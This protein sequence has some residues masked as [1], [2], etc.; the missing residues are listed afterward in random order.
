MSNYAQ[1]ERGSTPAVI[2][3]PRQYNAAADF[4]DRHVAEGRGERLALI[5]DAGSYSYAELQRRIDRAGNLL[6]EAGADAESRVMLC[7]LD[8]IDFPTLFFGAIKSGAVAVPVNTLLTTS[9]YDFMLRD[10]RARVLVVSRPLFDK[11]APILEGQPHLRTVIVAGGEVDGY[12]SLETLMARAPETLETADTTRDD[13][14]FWLYT[15]GSTGTPKGAMHLHSDMVSTAVLYGEGVLGIRPDDRIFS[16]AKM[17]FAYGLGNAISFPFYVGATTVAMAARPTPDAVMAVLKRHQPTLF[18]GVPTLYS[19]ILGAT[20]YARADGSERL[21]LCIS[22]G[23]ALPQE[24]GEAWEQRFGSPILDGLGST[25]MLHIFLSNR[26]GDVHYGTSGV[27]VPGYE[28]KIVDEEGNPVGVDTVGEL[29]VSGPSSA[30]AYW[31]NR[32][33]SLDTFIGRWTRTGDKYIVDADGYYHYCGRTDDML[34]VSG[35]WV[36]PFEVESALLAHETVLEVAV[37]GREDDQGLV[38]PQAFVVLKQPELASDE[39]VAELQLFV[40][41]RLA[42]YKYPRWVEFLDELP[43]TATGKIQRFK[44]RRQ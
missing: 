6:R 38:K 3:F 11:F 17:F 29:M 27:A 8:G 26:E 7:L 24:V 14:A 37:V 23:E 19:A 36:S 12:D 15:S 35:I 28:L 20:D 18:C 9:D 25:E 43:K 4:V 30:M 31:N 21:R 22:A 40:K 34:K 13:V 2:D 5:D 16:A 44:L 39:L 32:P 1:V 10:S 42:P 41:E 33:K